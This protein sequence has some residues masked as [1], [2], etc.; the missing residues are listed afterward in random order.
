MVDENVQGPELPDG[1][2]DDLRRVLLVG[3]VGGQQHRPPT[4]G[5]D[6]IRGV[7]GILMFRQVSDRD[8]GPL[9]GERDRDRAPYPESPPVMSARLPSSS[10]RPM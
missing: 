4:G 5:A 6:Q 7:L 1:P 8:V 9:L 3:K 10:P 2:L